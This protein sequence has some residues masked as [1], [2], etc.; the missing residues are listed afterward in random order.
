MGER[1]VVERWQ[2]GASEWEIERTRE[3]GREASAIRKP[4]AILSFTHVL[5]T[6]LRVGVG[7]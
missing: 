4:C 3:R 2:G 1:V 5:E 7:C 6:F